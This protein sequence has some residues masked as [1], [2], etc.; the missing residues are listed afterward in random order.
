MLHLILNVQPEFRTLIEPTLITRWGKNTQKLETLG[1][2]NRIYFV[3]VR[4]VVFYKES[5]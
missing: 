1:K 5:G 2:N 4:K 3:L